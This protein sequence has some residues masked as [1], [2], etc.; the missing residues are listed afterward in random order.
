MTCSCRQKAQQPAG[1]GQTQAAATGEA[2][3]GQGQPGRAPNQSTAMPAWVDDSPGTDAKPARTASMLPY[4]SSNPLAAQSPGGERQYGPTVAQ[5]QQQPM[6]QPQVQ[7]PGRYAASPA[8][9]GVQAARQRMEESG[10]GI[11]YNLSGVNIGELSGKI[12]FS[13]AVHFQD[14][15][16]SCWA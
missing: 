16:L 10:S 6:L 12:R 11:R 3:A 14:S 1:A 2:S 4:S 13:G 9:E 7:P 15:T 5:Q 8:Y